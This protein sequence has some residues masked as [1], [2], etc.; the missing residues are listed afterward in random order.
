MLGL[1][2]S[3]SMVAVPLTLWTCLL[4][5][6]WLPLATAVPRLARLPPSPFP[7]QVLCFSCS[8]WEGPSVG[9]CL[10]LTQPFWAILSKGTSSILGGLSPFPI[11]SPHLFLQ[12][13]YLQFVSPYSLIYPLDSHCLPH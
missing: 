3:K 9:T 7:K 11:S 6:C 10:L 1:C 5:Q 12:S 8:Y 4:I 13:T 2:S